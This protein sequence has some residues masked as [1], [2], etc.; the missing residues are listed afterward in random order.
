MSPTLTT[1]QTFNALIAPRSIDQMLFMGD[2]NAG[3]ALG[4][5]WTSW[6]STLGARICVTLS[7]N[8]TTLTA[9]ASGQY[10]TTGYGSGE[11]LITMSQQCA[12]YGQPMVIRMAHEFNGNWAATYGNTHELAAGFVAGWQHVVDVFR[13]NGAT[14]VLWC[15]CPN[16]FNVPYNNTID[17][18]VP[19]AS[20]VNWYPGDAY[21][22][23][24]AVDAYIMMG[25]TIVHTPHDLINPSWT[26]IQAITSKPFG[27]GEF[28]CSPN[29]LLGA[30]CGGKGPWYTLLFE[31]LNTLPNLVF[32]NQWQVPGNSNQPTDDWTISTSGTDLVAE[33]NFVN[34]VT[35]KPM[36][37]GTIGRWHS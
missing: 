23:I 14:N 15:W 24:V 31:Y 30:L 26:A 6:S 36:T 32:I 4:T 17:P 9:F 2:L 21:V 34:G 28:G 11:G 22:D 29:S 10:D 35:A 8:S 20:G 27:L 19:D 7:P 33:G 12:A 13:A 25:N 37:A 1:F 16:V 3:P 18:T 5:N